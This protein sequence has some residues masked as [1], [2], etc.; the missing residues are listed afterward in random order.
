MISVPDG[1]SYRASSSSS[2]SELHNLSSNASEAFQSI[3]RHEGKLN[4][5][6]LK[7]F[8]SAFFCF[9]IFFHPKRDDLKQ[10]RVLGKK[11][12]RKKN[13][14]DRFFMFWRMLRILSSCFE[15]CWGSSFHL[16]DVHF[17]QAILN[18]HLS[19]SLGIVTASSFGLS[20][21]KQELVVFQQK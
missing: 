18:G 6:F 9:K 12:S 7:K 10:S 14:G 4:Q 19:S 20:F 1:G 13:L 16:R 11:I 21:S 17:I 2:Q 8:F 15:E 5:S 3:V